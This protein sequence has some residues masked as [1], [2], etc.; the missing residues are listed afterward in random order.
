MLA[1]VIQ[2]CRVLTHGAE[3]VGRIVGWR[4]VVTWEDDDS[5]A[6]KFLEFRTAADI[7]FFREHSF[8]VFACK[9]TKKRLFCQIY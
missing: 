9:V 4:F 2:E 1:E 3:A 8:L 5:L 7:S 6:Y